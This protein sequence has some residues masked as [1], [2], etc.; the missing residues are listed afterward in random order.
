MA[1]EEKI[2]AMLAIVEQDKDAMIGLFNN[3]EDSIKALLKKLGTDLKVIDGYL[4]ETEKEFLG[5]VKDFLLR[6]KELP[7]Y[8]TWFGGSAIMVILLLIDV[9]L[10]QYAG[11]DWYPKFKA[12]IDNNLDVIETLTVDVVDIKEMPVETDK[13]LS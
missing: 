7:G 13:E 1:N 6:I 3:V 4:P 2:N 11:K 5:L 10:D 8:L 12:M 9:G